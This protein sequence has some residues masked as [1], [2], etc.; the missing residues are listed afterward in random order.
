MARINIRLDEGLLERVKERAPEGGMT[1]WIV[2]LMEKD[3]GVPSK[4]AKLERLMARVDALE[5]FEEFIRGRIA[6]SEPV[7]P[8][9]Q[10]PTT[11]RSEPAVE[12][13]GR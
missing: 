11:T 5:D 4:Q 2:R 12:M 10:M 8:A 7:K 13:D 9:R 6:K 3:L 1:A